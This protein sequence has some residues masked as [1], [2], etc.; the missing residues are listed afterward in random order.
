MKKD[1]PNPKVEDLIVA[2][3]PTEDP[4]FYEVFLINLKDEPLTN[5]LITSKGYGERDDQKVET[6][7]LRYF[8][9]NIPG[10]DYVKIELISAEVFDLTNEYWISFTWMGHMYDKKYF[11]VKGSIIEENFTPVPFIAK[12]GVMI[13]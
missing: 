6:T 13:R 12:K 10:L 3:I 2:V 5:I 1:I 11:F 7:I 9:E 4:N 8:V